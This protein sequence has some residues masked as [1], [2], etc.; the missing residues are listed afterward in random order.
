MACYE[1]DAK[2]GSK[3]AGLVDVPSMKPGVKVQ[4]AT[5]PPRLTMRVISFHQ[6]GWSNQW[7]DVPA[8]TRS[9]DSEEME[10]REAESAVSYCSTEPR[11]HISLRL[12]ARSAK[13]SG[14]AF[15]LSRA[16]AELYMAED[17]SVPTTWP[18]RGDS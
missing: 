9:T 5:V 2:R 11:W 10:G 18:K 13:E 7:A 6:A 16:G 12:I 8:V 4:H 17:R 14:P 15:T 3:I 1:M